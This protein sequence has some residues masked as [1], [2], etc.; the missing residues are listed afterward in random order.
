MIDIG[1]TYKGVR[2][3]SRAKPVGIDYSR[4]INRSHSPKSR[5]GGKI[6]NTKIIGIFANCMTIKNQTTRVKTYT[7]L[8]RLINKPNSTIQL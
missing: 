1:P 2:L 5:E 7:M 6:Y 8:K 3:I 4:L